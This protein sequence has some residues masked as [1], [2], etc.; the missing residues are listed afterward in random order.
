MKKILSFFLILCAIEVV[1]L[2]VDTHQYVTTKSCPVSINGHII[3]AVD[4]Q[5]NFSG[6]AK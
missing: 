4:T 1:L 6:M 5:I 2:G 3:S